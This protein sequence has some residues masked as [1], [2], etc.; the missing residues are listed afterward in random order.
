MGK[1]EEP[2][3]TYEFLVR[4][5]DDLAL[6][7]NIYPTTLPNFHGVIEEKSPYSWKEEFIGWR[8][9]FSMRN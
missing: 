9:A 5:S 1:E 3:V 7:K 4:D 8:T 2:Q 6:M